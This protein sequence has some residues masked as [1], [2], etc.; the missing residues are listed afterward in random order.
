MTVQADEA[1]DAPAPAA[2]APAAGG[3]VAP[4][5]ANT[6]GCE[7][8]ARDGQLR[9][10]SR[11]AEPLRPRKPEPGALTKRYSCVYYAQFRN[12]DY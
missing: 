7:A 3:R 11:V 6:A 10:S 9:S 5:P 4:A 12:L 1:R 8:R 2:V